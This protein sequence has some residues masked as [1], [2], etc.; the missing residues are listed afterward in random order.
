MAPSV[1]EMAMLFTVVASSSNLTYEFSAI[2]SAE[3]RTAQSDS[4]PH[5]GFEDMGTSED[6]AALPEVSAIC[7]FPSTNLNFTKSELRV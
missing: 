5:S 7:P 2:P 6:F 4:F 1:S 3:V